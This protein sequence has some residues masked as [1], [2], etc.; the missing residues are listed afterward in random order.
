MEN[1]KEQVVAEWKAIN[2]PRLKEIK[3]ANPD[4]YSAI[5]LALNYLNK[6]LTGEELPAEVEEEVEEEVEVVETQ[7]SGEGFW[8]IMTEQELIDKYGS[9]NKTPRFNYSGKMN[10]LLGKRVKDLIIDDLSE[11]AIGKSLKK[12][13]NII[14][15][16]S[17]DPE[18]SEWLLFNDFIVF[19]TSST[20]ATLTSPEEDYVALTEIEIIINNNNVKP[21]DVHGITFDLYNKIIAGKKLSELTKDEDD[22]KKVFNDLKKGLNANVLKFSIPPKFWK[23][24]NQQSQTQ[25]G[26]KVGDKVKLPLTKSVGDRYGNSNA[27]STAIDKGQKYLYV[28]KIYPGDDR[29]DLWYQPKDSGDYF[30]I[31]EDNIELYEEPT[32]NSTTTQPATTFNYEDLVGKRLKMLIGNTNVSGKE[33]V[34]DVVQLKRR[35]RQDKVYVLKEISSNPLTNGH[36]IEE[37]LKNEIIEILLTKGKTWAIEV[38]N[39]PTTQT[40]GF[41]LLETDPKYI[42]VPITSFEPNNGDRKAPTQS[43]GVL[44]KAF[45][46]TSIEN[47]ILNT[48]FKGNDG[49]WYKINVGKGGVWTWKKA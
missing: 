17:L 24:V 47:E 37:K 15:N 26:F 34:F 40:T 35:N 21:V 11:D 27:I 31:S 19:D 36:E 9:I 28:V 30:S 2:E 38:I 12:G 5:N 23:L 25:Q 14:S 41:E 8:R 43:A 1:T 39:K 3:S 45:Q 16:P 44:K 18:R 49:Q 32:I 4:L 48:K 29:I 33:R 42:S 6:K 7:P 22:F 20:Q 46:N 13:K 10:W